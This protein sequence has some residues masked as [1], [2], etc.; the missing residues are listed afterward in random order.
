MIDTPSMLVLRNDAPDPHVHRPVHLG[1]WC[2]HGT[3]V[4]RVCCHSAMHCIGVAAEPH[5]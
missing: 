5:W 2:M 4:A 1:D 3:Y